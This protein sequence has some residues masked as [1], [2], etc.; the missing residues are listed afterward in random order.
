MTLWGLSPLLT[1][2]CTNKSTDGTLRAV[3]IA[4]IISVL[5]SRGMQFITLTES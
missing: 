2:K 1:V 3:C 5:S 4:N